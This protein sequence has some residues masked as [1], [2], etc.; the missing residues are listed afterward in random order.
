[1]NDFVTSFLVV[2]LGAPALLI[3]LN[4]YRAGIPTQ[5]GT[6]YALCDFIAT[7]RA[8]ANAKHERDRVLF[9]GLSNVMT[10]L[11]SHTAGEVLDCQ[12]VNMGMNANLTNGVLYELLEQ[13]L[14]PGDTLVIVM[15]YFYFTSDARIN[16][17]L[18]VV[19]DYIFDCSPTAYRRLSLADFLKLSLIQRPNQILE[20]VLR[21]IQSRTGFN[22]RHKYRP[23]FPMFDPA[24]EGAALDKHGDWT[25][26]TESQRPADYRTIV[27]QSS[28][29]HSQTFSTPGFNST[30]DSVRSLRDFL[31]WA[32]AKNIRLL[33][34]WPIFCAHH[35]DGFDQLVERIRDFYSE[36]GV[37]VVGKPEDFL[38]PIDNFFDSAYH[39]TIEGAEIY[40]RQL[41]TELRPLLLAHRTVCSSRSCGQ[42]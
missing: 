41:A 37:P 15:P 32:K 14:R 23:A 33:A 16:G 5:M 24:T 18:T 8:L 29:T 42:T 2:L 34:S 4:I 40:T 27:A 20:G 11:R 38:Y 17:Q 12:V 7:R 6:S 36:S 30:G 1:M 9:F 3:A 35:R 26:N 21:K 13:V 22:L 31:T 10:G 39:A 19:R 25:L 28:I